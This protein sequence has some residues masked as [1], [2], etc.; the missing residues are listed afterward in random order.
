MAIEQPILLDVPEQ[1]TSERLLL[2]IPRGGDS[3]FVWPAVVDS[4]NELAPWMPWAYPTAKEQGVEEFCRRAAANFILREQFHYSLY[5][6]GTET[7]IGV[8]GVAR[9]KW[10]V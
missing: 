10:N 1:L 3:K 7:C 5:L 2:R 4:Q 8:C 6:S 9:I